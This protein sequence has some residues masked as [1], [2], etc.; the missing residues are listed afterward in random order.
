MRRNRNP[1]PVF[2]IM[3]VAVTAGGEEVEFCFG[4]ECEGGAVQPPI[5]TP[6]MPTSSED[7]GFSF[8]LKLEV[9]IVPGIPL[10]FLR[11]VDSEGF[12]VLEIAAAAGLVPGADLALTY[13]ISSNVYGTLPLGPVVQGRER[14]EVSRSVAGGLGTIRVVRGGDRYTTGVVPLGGDPAAI[15]QGWL[16]PVGGSTGVVTMTRVELD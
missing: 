3:A 4:P 12:S 11:A 15:D 13:Q 5:S 1:W 16:E 6:I 10:T 14:I 2:I 8:V 9:D 7:L